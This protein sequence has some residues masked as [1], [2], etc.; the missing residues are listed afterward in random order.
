M[1]LSTVSG[2]VA[3]VT[4]A[5]KGIGFEVARALAADGVMVWVAARDQTRGAAAVR[6]LRDDGLHVEQLLLDVIDESSVRHAAERVARE[7]GRLDILVNNAGIALDAGIAPSE[8]DSE[9]IRATFEVNLFGA[10]RVTQA[11][12]P[13]LRKSAAGRIVMV[14]SDIGSHHHQTN[15]DFPYYNMNP[16]AYAASKAALNAV[17]IAFSKELRDTAIKVNAANPSFTATDLND[18]RGLLTVAQGAAP[19]LR[20]ATLPDD[21]PTGTFLGPQGPEPW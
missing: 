6:Q 21:G 1:V 13:L 8:V 5:N 7:S 14:S 17:T 15:P 4:G 9:Q 16:M 19:L 10:I 12:L 18:H 20:L 2:T 11:F 3:L